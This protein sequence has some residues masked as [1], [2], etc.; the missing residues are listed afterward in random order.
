MPAARVSTSPVRCVMVP[1]PDEPNQ[2]L[3]GFC[4]G[5][6]HE[7]LPVPGAERVGDGHGQERR[8]QPAHRDQVV[9]IVGHL[10][11]ARRDRHD[12][13]RREQERVA[14]GRARRDHLRA[15]AARGAGLVLDDHLLAQRRAEPLAIE[16]RHLVGRAAR[17]VGH[18]QA[19]RPG[20]P[21][22]LR[23][24][25]CRQQGGKRRQR[26]STTTDHAFPP[27]FT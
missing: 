19:D 24:R 18:D 25:A 2:Y 22:S 21:R 14:V 27:V 9:G 11:H 13:G 15:D 12:G 7:L 1:S 6:D 8:R 4:L 5:E 10:P 16:P 20:G 3:P 26:R 23:A 17:P